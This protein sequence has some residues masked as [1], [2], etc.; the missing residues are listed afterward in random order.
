MLV[1]LVSHFDVVLF[2]D[3]P[4]DERGGFIVSVYVLGL[5]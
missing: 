2:T 5:C 1:S 3:I 4:V